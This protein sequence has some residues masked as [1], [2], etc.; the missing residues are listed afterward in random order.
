MKYSFI[1][2]AFNEEKY[3]GKCILSIRNSVTCNLEDYEIIVVN[4]QSTDRTSGIAMTH[5]C[6]VIYSIRDNIAK[7]R[8]D[9]AKVAKGET[10]I[11]VDAD[12]T[13][14]RGLLEYINP[15]AIGGGSLV[16]LDHKTRIGDWIVNRWNNYCKDK[17]IFTGS[18]IFIKKEYFF[19]F[20]EDYYIAEDIIFSNLLNDAATR[21]NQFTQLIQKYGVITSDRKL[22]LYSL[23]EHLRFWYSF[24][25]NKEKVLFNR[26]SCFLWYS[27]RRETV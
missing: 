6:K 13:V 1:I 21:H 14:S 17:F 27:G 2:P 18:F 22:R 10:L 25:R 9:G 20:P 3:I 8:N 5:C 26:S 11:F 23:F 15:E 16:Q 12:S 4:N 7:V 19:G 24:W